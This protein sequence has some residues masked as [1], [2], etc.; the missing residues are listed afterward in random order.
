MKPLKSSLD[1][2]SHLWGIIYEWKVDEYPEFSFK[3]CREI[4][5]IAQ[6]VKKELPE[7]VSED[8]EGYKGLSY[9]KLT[10][11]LV[12]AVKELKAQNEKQ[13]AEIEELRS[14][15]KELKS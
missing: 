12:E 3:K 14:M 11:V 10:A 8:K 13:K 4:G 1:K 7:L 15:I 2:I 6:D 9:A 5:L